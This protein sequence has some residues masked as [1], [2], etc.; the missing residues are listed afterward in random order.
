MDA[1]L[2][3]RIETSAE[4]SAAALFGGAV[5]YAAFEWLGGFAFEPQRALYAAAAGV[6]AFVFCSLAFKAASRSQSKLQVPVFDLREFDQF[7]PDELLLT[8]KSDG[9]L[10][11]T[12][13]AELIL[14]DA[15][16]IQPIAS[17]QSEDGLVLDNVRAEIMADSRVVRLFDRDAMPTPGEL[18]SR[19]DNYLEQGSAATD[20][21]DASQA[22]SDALAELKRSLR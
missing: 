22:L 1:K 7:G 16:R 18:K 13:L 20:P 6:A 12:E 11:L 14:T 5:G 17:P 21:V 3:E 9:E 2:I 19:V 4:R 8:D 15:D 10:L